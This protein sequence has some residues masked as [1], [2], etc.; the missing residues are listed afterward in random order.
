MDAHRGCPESDGRFLGKEG[1]NVKEGGKGQFRR[2]GYATGANE[3]SSSKQL[4]KFRFDFFH[5]VHE[6]IHDDVEVEILGRVDAGHAELFQD[7]GIIRGDDAAHHDRDMPQPR[8]AHAVHD[9][10]HQGNV[11]A[12]ENGEA[13]QGDFFLFRGGHDFF[14]GEADAVIGD[15]EPA[16]GGAHGDLL[17]AI[18]M[19][20]EAGLGHEEFGSHAKLQGRVS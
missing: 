9:I 10:A 6:I 16:I 7:E 13:D 19:A 1:E 15:V 17:G 20:V 5:Q 3:I 4:H 14:R 12:G 2:H 18:G 8:L 11:A